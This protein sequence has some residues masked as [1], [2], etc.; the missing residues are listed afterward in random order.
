MSGEILEPF[1]IVLPD[2]DDQGTHPG[3]TVRKGFF[4][5]S[6]GK[7]VFSIGTKWEVVTSATI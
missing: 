6:A 7:L 4:A 1:Q 5:L 2:L 3:N